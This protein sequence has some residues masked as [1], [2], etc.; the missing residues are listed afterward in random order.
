[1]FALED[2]I[3]NGNSRG[4]EL[5]SVEK[6]CIDSRGRV[7]NQQYIQNHHGDYPVYSS[8]TINEGIFGYIDTFDFDG[9]YVTWTTDGVNAGT[10]FYRNGRFNCTNVCGVLKAKKNN[11]NLRYLAYI[12]NSVAYKYVN[13]VGNDKLMNDAMRKILV[14]LPKKILQDQFA[15]YVQSIDKF[16]F[17][18]RSN[19][20]SK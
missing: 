7:I 10:V 9:E 6:L 12:L 15:D 8:Q 16:Q 18:D 4:Y 17:V 3:N 20:I 5:Y 1:M 19:I 2:F 11:V 13:H 14:P